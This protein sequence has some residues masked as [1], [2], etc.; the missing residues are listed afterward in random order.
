MWKDYGGEWYDASWINFQKKILPTS[1]TG[2][3]KWEKKKMDPR[4]RGILLYS[5]HLDPAI[6][7]Y[8]DIHL[9]M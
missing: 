7:H 4:E 8:L 9:E 2:W 5:E 6:I 1:K 3:K